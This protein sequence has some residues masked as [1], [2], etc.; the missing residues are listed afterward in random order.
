MCSLYSEARYR[1]IEVDLEIA[2]AE[3][4]GNHG[5]RPLNVYSPVL[6]HVAHICSTVYVVKCKVYVVKCM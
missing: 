2:L 6:A 3:K 4:L 1:T 5:V